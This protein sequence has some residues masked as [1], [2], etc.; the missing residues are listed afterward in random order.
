MGRPIAFAA[1]L[2]VAA[3]LAPAPARAQSPTDA[4]ASLCDALAGPEYARA[5][6]L[7]RYAA[8]LCAADGPCASA[9]GQVPAPRPAAL[10]AAIRAN[11]EPGDLSDAAVAR[12]LLGCTA[13]ARPSPREAVARILL[14]DAVGSQVSRGTCPAGETMVPDAETGLFRCECLQGC[15]Q[16]DE[17][18]DP[19]VYALFAIVVAF[20]TARYVQTLARRRE[21][22]EAIR[23][24][25]PAPV[26]VATSER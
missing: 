12:R 19:L 16:A 17:A 26:L 24:N 22:M 10:E 4:L 11:L 3:L 21:L 18:R 8:S 14:L 20:E 13:S 2:L 15:S 7:V 25:D 1:L 23:R 9:Y 5:S 6:D